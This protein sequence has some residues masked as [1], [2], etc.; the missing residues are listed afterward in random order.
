M[1]EINLHTWEEFEEQVHLLELESERITHDHFVAVADQL[2]RALGI[3]QA[4]NDHDSF[5]RFSKEVTLSHLSPVNVST[6]DFVEPA[7]L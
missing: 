3:E 2:N 5:D 6:C 4:S 1:K 7:I